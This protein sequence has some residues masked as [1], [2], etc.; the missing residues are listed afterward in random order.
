MEAKKNKLNRIIS[1]Y[2]MVGGVV[3]FGA[4]IFLIFQILPQLLSE[5]VPLSYQVLSVAILFYA[6][7]GYLLSFFA[8]LF[9][10]KQ[11]KKGITLSIWSQIMQIPTFAIAGF[12]YLFV[13]GLEF[14][15]ITEGVYS[16][17]FA[18]YLG[19][20]WDISYNPEGAPFFIG[21][22]FIAIA[23]LVYLMKERNKSL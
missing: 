18:T 7:G 3:G 4:T 11:E 23:I 17:N 16:M 5:E 19:S 15:L 20:H 21:I 13:S 8:G 12:S 14:F 10:W 2:E 9:L 1:I 22:N 6:I